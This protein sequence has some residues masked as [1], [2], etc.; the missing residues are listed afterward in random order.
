MSAFLGPIHH[1]MFNNIK[2]V[3]S[4]AFAIASA[5]ENSGDET[6]AMAVKNILDEYG[7]RFEGKD[8]AEFV[9]NSPI[10]Q[11]I[12]GM[13]SKTEV[14]EAQI[15]AAA[16]GKFDLILEVAFNH[17]KGAAAKALDGKDQKPENLNGI[18]QYIRENQLEGMPCDPSGTFEQLSESSL[19]YSHTTCNH[20]QNWGYAD[21]DKEKMCKLTCEWLKGFTQGLNGGVSFSVKNSIASGASS[22]AAELKL[23]A[24]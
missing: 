11:F 1:W 3:E 22:C 5:V 7:E 9:G 21:V 17:G 12:S 8:L 2:A 6:I 23:T 20:L 4:R 15:V 10:H 16:D 19:I 24:D 14:F 18:E 13:L